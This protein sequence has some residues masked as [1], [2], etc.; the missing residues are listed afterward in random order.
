MVIVYYYSHQICSM[1]N[2]SQL[3]YEE[4]KGPTLVLVGINVIMFI[5]TSIMG[6]TIA[7]IGEEPLFLFGFSIYSFL[8]GKFWTPLTSIFTHAGLA[9]IG[10]NMIG[11][12][13]YGFKLEEEG[14][15]DKQIYFAYLFTGIFSG[16]LSALIS[17]YSY[18]TYSVGAS[19]AVFGI[20]GVNYGILKRINHPEG[21]RVLLF[22]III[23]ILSIRENVNLFAHL[24]GLI[25][26]I[27]LGKS[28]FFS[29]LK[30]FDSL[31]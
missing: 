15:N 5:I 4:I 29:K 8:G 20:L 9:H 12:F 7:D 27:F 23:F 6:G 2:S 21:K 13:I 28:E 18:F 3:N 30:T 31:K 10:S 25:L 19:G 16:I 11:L 22:A 24:Y 17:P 26:G 14:Y 1:S